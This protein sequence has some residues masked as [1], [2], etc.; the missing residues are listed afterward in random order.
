MLAPAAK[1]APRIE[2]RYKTPQPA[3]TYFAVHERK[4]LDA[5]RARIAS[6]HPPAPNA[7]LAWTGGAARLATAF[8]T[9]LF[10]AS[11]GTFNLYEKIPRLLYPSDPWR[12]IDQHRD[13]DEGR[14]GESVDGKPAKGT[15]EWNPV[16]GLAFAVEVEAQLRESLARMGL[17]F[18]AVAEQQAHVDV[19]PE[20][21]IA[22]HPFDH[23]VA[24]LLCD[25]TIAHYVADKHS[26]QR[27][28]TDARTAFKHGL[29]LAILEWQGQH[30]PKLW[31][32]VKVVEP[33][34]PTNE[35]LAMAV[36]ERGDGVNHTE[37]AYGITGAAPY[38][39]I[40]PRWARELPGA[41]EHAPNAA[42][43]DLESQSALALADSK[44]GDDAAVAQAARTT[45]PR[46]QR[47]PDL[48]QLAHVLDQ[49]EKQ[50]RV[51]GEWLGPWKLSHLVGPSLRWVI[52]HR[53]HLDDTPYA[54]LRKWAPAIEGQ[55]KTLLEATGELLEVAEAGAR[56]P[57]RAR[58][59]HSAR[60]CR[61]SGLRWASRISSRAPRHR[62][63]RR[64]SGSRCSRSSFSSARCARPTR[65]SRTWSRTSRRPTRSIES[66]SPPVPKPASKDSSAP[67]SRCARR[68]S[69]VASST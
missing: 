51:V 58:R 9:A 60:C 63:P 66:T 68:Q 12:V 24:R 4:F 31:N 38:F 14:P 43:D 20:A 69:R 25:S 6:L 50:L 62:W 26:R 52:K 23:V 41:K 28:D 47:K 15:I 49:S 27:R 16:V 30:D 35:E 33:V 21:L 1:P 10:T 65:R 48:A 36:F 13:L 45:D 37:Y 54:T 32:W 22:S 19:R 5:I 34:D 61:R 39:C 2:D 3:S 40:P 53:D 56:R 42:T 44:L 57:R 29:R 67:R 55:R 46:H 17:R 64:D 8:D 18:V 11:G 7:R 59:D